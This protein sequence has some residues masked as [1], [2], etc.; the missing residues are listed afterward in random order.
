LVD[1]IFSWSREQPPKRGKKEGFLG[2]IP[3][4]KGGIMKLELGI[5]KAESFDFRFR[6]VDSGLRN[7]LRIER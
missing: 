5:R 6:I 1:P 7:E 2:E 4:K 3:V